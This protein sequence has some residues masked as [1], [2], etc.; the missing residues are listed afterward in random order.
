MKRNKRDN[1]CCETLSVRG[2]AESEGELR[3]IEFREIFVPLLFPRTKIEIKLWKEVCSFASVPGTRDKQMEI[4]LHS[5]SIMFSG[6]SVAARS[7]CN[8]ITFGAR[9]SD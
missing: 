2:A 8:C 7:A 3:R 4:Y 1:G 9:N 6:T 5:A